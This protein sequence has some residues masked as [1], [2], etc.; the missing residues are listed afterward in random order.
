MAAYEEILH[1]LQP[2]YGLTAGLSNKTIIK[3][4]HQALNEESSAE[5][6]LPED[7]RERL[8]SGRL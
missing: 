2:I 8:S 3:L 1:S 7:L 6:F 5:E 4:V